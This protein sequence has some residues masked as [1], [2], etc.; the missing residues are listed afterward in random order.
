MKTVILAEKPSQ[1]KEYASAMEMHS[2][3][4]GYIE[5]KDKL[6]PEGAIVTY[7]F[8]HL[9]ELCLPG[10]YGE[11]YNKWSLAN[12]PIF[13]EMKYRVAKDKIEQFS[14]VKGHLQKA[15]QIIIATDCDR[16]GELIAWL[17]INQAG[18]K[19]NEKKIDRLW[20][21]SL[22]K[23]AIRK[24]FKSLK[25]A[26]ETYDKF[27]EAQTRQKSDWLVGMNLSPLY[28]LTLQEKGVQ[29]VFPIGRVQTPTL[30]MVYKRQQ[31]IEN[32]ISKKYFEVELRGNQNNNQWTAK[33]K[34]KQ[35]FDSKESCKKFLENGKLKEG[36]QNV[37]VANI[38]KEMK[39]TKSPRLFSLSALQVVMSK[40]EKVSPKKVLE[41]VQKLYEKKLLTYPRTDSVYIT[42]NELE[43]LLS[44][45]ESY[46]KLFSINQHLDHVDKKT[47]FVNSKKVQE[48]HA[49][50]PTKKIPSQT[51]LKSLTDLERN[52]Y[53]LVTRTT[54]AMFAETYQYEETTV[55][56]VSNNVA[57]VAKGKVEK[58]LGWK[59]IL[60]DVIEKETEEFTLP[61]LELDTFIEMDLQVISKDTKPPKSFT[62]GT[63]IQAM[64][65]A[66][67]ELENEEAQSILKD[68]EGIGTEATRADVIE[69]LK[70]QDYINVVKNQLEVTKKGKQIGK[71]L[72][73]DKLFSSA[74][75]TAVWEKDLKSISEDALTQDV[76][77]KRIKHLVKSYIKQVPQNL[78]NISKGTEWQEMQKAQSVGVC[79][80]CGKDIVDR[81]K[82]YG[83]VG[84]K[85]KPSCSFTLMKK[86]MGKTLPQKDVSLLLS[87]GST[88]TIKGFVSKKG[89]KFDAQL[90]WDKD[91][92]TFVFPN[93]K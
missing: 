36:N 82:M 45:K 9:V 1:A 25:S 56:L 4:K 79:P 86:I 33:L 5:I 93:K 17:I 61:S 11:E 31:A 21:N 76:F 84:Y 52:I 64:K 51:D 71:V 3:K 23:E 42:E 55:D 19:R 69:K 54:L 41:S 26:N 47:R 37:L 48:H 24:G 39:E 43:Y 10:D 46:Q 59:S 73:S 57:F 28:T 58:L 2:I 32:F 81:G 87:E 50:I 44:L 30:M 38:Q 40:K 88:R 62:E 7:G 49:I 14:I 20:I 80:N 6:F 83:C 16:E 34:E 22:E 15:T 29:G 53:E 77:L 70:S 8:G 13:P 92:I 68:V 18:I 27:L 91:K 60:N 65:T 89:N 74:E 66:G 75:M 72:E 90:K 85:D 78:A 67:K 12:L 63:L 35:Q